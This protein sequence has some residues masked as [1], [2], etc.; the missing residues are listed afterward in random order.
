MCGYVYCV[1]KQKLK[2][3]SSVARIHKLYSID[4]DNDNGN[5]ISLFRHK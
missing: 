1:P 4:N 2:Y 5:E 3:S